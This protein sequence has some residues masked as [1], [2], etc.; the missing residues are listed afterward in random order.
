M[1]I[2]HFTFHIKY[3]TPGGNYFLAVRFVWE[4]QQMDWPFFLALCTF[5]IFTAVI[6]VAVYQIDRIVNDGR[7]AFVALERRL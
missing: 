6:S 4:L 3:I 1:T 7:L 2:I 5:N